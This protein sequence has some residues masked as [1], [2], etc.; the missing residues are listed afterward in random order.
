MKVFGQ[1]GWDW[2]IAR[3]PAQGQKPDWRTVNRRPLSSQGLI[4]YWQ[5]ST[6]LV[7]VRFRKKTFY[8]LLDIDYSSDY[9]SVEGI[10]KIR[11]ALEKIGIVRTLLIRSS[12]SQ[13]LHLYIPLAEKI[14]TFN[15]AAGLRVILDNEG[16]SV[17]AGQLEIFPNTKAYA[18][19]GT[20]SLYNAHRLPLQPGSGSCLLD[21]DLNPIDGGLE[22]FFT[23]WQ[24]SAENQDVRRL[25]RWCWRARAKLKKRQ[26]VCSCS[27][28][29]E[30]SSEYNAS[31]PVG[32]AWTGPGQTNE[33]LGKFARHGYTALNLTG[34]SLRN[35]IVKTAENTPGYR[36]FCSHKDKIERRAR[37][38]ARCVERNPEG[39]YLKRSTRKKGNE[40]KVNKNQLKAEQTK[41]RIIDAVRELKEAGCWPETILRRVEVLDEHHGIKRSTLYKRQYMPYWH[42]KYWVEPEATDAITDELQLTAEIPLEKKKLPCGSPLNPC[43]AKEFHTLHP[44][45]LCTPNF[46]PSRNDRTPMV[47]P[48]AVHFFQ[49]NEPAMN[50]GAPSLLQKSGKA[51]G[52]P[53]EEHEQ[54]KLPKPLP[55]PRPVKKVTQLSLVPRGEVTAATPELLTQK[56]R[57]LKRQDASPRGAPT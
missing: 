36:E 16:F 2:I 56:L 4:K 49:K 43:P 30:D 40:S 35:F 55:L 47:L 44:M 34:R 5:D 38:W 27:K 17:R 54:Q 11:E 1:Q 19:N 52:E 10:R 45:K 33:L 18:S 3:K 23:R 51:P 32:A 7:G 46:Y 9:W 29:S 22:T 8:A 14:K 37:D 48:P 57:A 31:P 50:Q 53:S 42:P 6:R 24:T 28:S 26:N 39:S 15:F 41:A 12:S 20:F 21:D 25:K 13:G